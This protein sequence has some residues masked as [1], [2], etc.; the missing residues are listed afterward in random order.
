MLIRSLTLEN[1]KSYARAT[2]EFSPGTNA[3][4]GPNGAGK[5]T[6]LEAIGFALFDHLPY[7]RPDFVRAS[8]GTAR[9]AVDYLSDFD[10][11][12]YRVI[13]SCGANSAYT[14]LDL[15]L[16]MKICEG[17]AD[18][19]QFLRL[20]LGIDEDTEPEELFK[21][22]VGVPQGSFTVSFLET[23]RIRKA[24]FDPL[25]KVAEYR[26]AW[27][28]LREPLSLL[29]QR[30]EALAVEVGRLEGELKRLPTV[31]AEAGKLTAQIKRG[32]IELRAAQVELTAA[33]SA[34]KAM[35]VKREHLQELR[36]MVE[37]Q[38]RE[39]AE[40]GRT[41][42]TARQRLTESERAVTTLEAN[43]TGHEAYRAAQKAQGA[44]NERL[45][46]RR[47]LEEER[48]GVQTL[49]AR[50]ETQADAQERALSEIAEAE[51][52]AADLA[53]AAA[54][55]EKLEAELRDAQRQADQ[56]KDADARVQREQTAVEAAQAR[57]GTL[58][59]ELA[60]AQE[61]EASLEPLQ[62]HLETLQQ[63]KSAEQ[64]NEA[65]M[66][67]EQETIQK[68]GQQLRTS[69]ESP[70]CPICEQPLSAEDREQL[71]QRLR[72]RWVELA[73][74]SQASAETIRKAEVERVQARATLSQQER[75]LRALP[76]QNAVETADRELADL[77]SRLTEASETVEALK[78]APERLGWLQ[79]AL[80]TLSDPR[81]RRD[82]AIQQVQ[83]R[84]RVEEALQ[85]QRAQVSQKRNALAELDERLAE[86]AD[87]DAETAR[88]SSRLKKFQ[89]A[90]DLYRRNQ[91]AA[92]ALS[93]R[94]EEVAE[95]EKTLEAAQVRYEDGQKQLAASS[96]EFDEERFQEAEAQVDEFRGRSA[97][98]AAELGQWRERLIRA[99][100]EIAQ[101]QTSEK[102]LATAQSR[103][104]RL[105]EQEEVLQFLRSVIHE[106]GPF[107]TKSLVQQI[108][109]SA[110][111][112]FGQ[113][114]EDYTRTLR[115]EED[116]GIILEVDGRERTFPQLS[117]G[118][119]MSA[120]LAVRLALLQEMSS[121]GVAFFDEP[122]TNLDETRRGALARQIVGVHGFEQMF[123]IS[124]D[125]SFDQATE[126]LIRVEKRNGTSEI[127]YE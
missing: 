4:V 107:I 103:R 50:A 48:A 83:G 80:K 84:G 33:E 114:M 85:L 125:D 13:R 92:E 36:R 16:D 99:K 104:D 115:W 8:Q 6:I 20:H 105:A 28:R 58:G 43:R 5:T 113:I 67:A 118:E 54:E 12:A 29:S 63:T 88:I 121:I 72:K 79:E 97:R 89:T 120:A 18:V 112:L 127:H 123:I 40:K 46:Q 95:A 122:T 82:A 77:K 76:R 9:V 14:I 31:R 47:R 102:R 98:L 64:A 119:Q 11:R 22:A 30:Q 26:R 75:A 51:K 87:L 35:E 55:Q 7:S 69:E 66:R 93:Q 52:T 42:A 108:S 1:V 126:K 90:D 27:E 94:Q 25:L 61:I 74:A 81:R 59:K 100:E 2:V 10:E 70:I 60:Q 38:E 117:G 39:A 111:Q 78:K 34:R 110:N 71:L 17:K 68:Q 65:R 23:P 21:N 24:V 109:Y 73:E 45:A 41:L 44:V 56:L 91:A 15:E 49:L 106:A 86:F 62:A 19:M 57:L 124:H 101:L 37:L 96:R 116:Y 53:D 3:V 32:E